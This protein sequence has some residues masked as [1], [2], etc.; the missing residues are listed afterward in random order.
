MK[1]RILLTAALLALATPGYGEDDTYYETDDKYVPPGYESGIAYQPSYA[2][3]DTYGKPYDTGYD[4]K[5]YL[6]DDTY[7]TD[8][9][10]Y[11]T[12]DYGK[13]YG[14]YEPSY[15]VYP[16]TDYYEGDDYTPSIGYDTTPPGYVVPDVIYPASYGTSY[17]PGDGFAI[18]WKQVYLKVYLLKYY[19]HYVEDYRNDIIAQINKL[20]QKV[21]GWCRGKENRLR[22]CSARAPH[23]RPRGLC[24]LLALISSFL[25]F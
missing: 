8:D 2:E 12:D 20:S 3:Y 18:L 1:F 16:S 19:V 25:Y 7:V 14:T 4:D 17:G 10:G 9:K 21:F 11:E 13:G 6:T 24:V 23:A 22:L 15:A 5:G